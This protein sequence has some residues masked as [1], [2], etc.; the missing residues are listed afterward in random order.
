MKKKAPFTGV[1]EIEGKSTLKK[2][3]TWN[4]RATTVG[5][6]R[7][8]QSVQPHAHK[9]HLKVFR[10]SSKVVGKASN[11]TRDHVKQ[12]DAFVVVSKGNHRKPRRAKHAGLPHSKWQ[13]RW[14]QPELKFARGNP[15]IPKMKEDLER[16]G[17]PFFL[18]DVG[19]GA[20]VKNLA[21]S[22]DFP[23][24]QHKQKCKMFPNNNHVFPLDSTRVKFFYWQSPGFSQCQQGVRIRTQT[25][26]LGQEPAEFQ[27]QS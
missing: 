23:L 22:W 18:V 9:V 2:V 13:L 27:N 3:Y 19:R 12:D 4:K 5:L 15:T 14:S 16:T 17:L 24:S 1:L 26:P 25:S 11:F 20:N 6:G 21:V 7:G 8:R 10:G